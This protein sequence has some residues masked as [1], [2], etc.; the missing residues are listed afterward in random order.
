MSFV[1]SAGTVL[2]FYLFKAVKM[3]FFWLVEL[4]VATMEGWAGLVG[5][6]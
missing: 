6:A 3:R 5:L 2:T 4:A 1:D